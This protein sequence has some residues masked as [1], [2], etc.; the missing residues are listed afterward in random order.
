M[1]HTVSPAK[2]DQAMRDVDPNGIG[3]FSIIF[4]FA[5]I[6]VRKNGVQAMLSNSQTKGKSDGEIAEALRDAWIQA[7]M[8]HIP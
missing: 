7:H 4:N 1:Q 2:I 8:N 6:C 3:Y 5:G